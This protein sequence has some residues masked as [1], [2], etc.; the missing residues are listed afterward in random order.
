MTHVTNP[1]GSNKILWPIAKNII[2][3]LAR[4]M[5][6]YHAWS[7]GGLTPKLSGAFWA[8]S[9]GFQDL[10]PFPF[11]SWSNSTHFWKI[12]PGFP[13]QGNTL[14]WMSRVS[15]PR[16]VFVNML[17]KKRRIQ[18]NTFEVELWRLKLT[19]LSFFKCRIFEKVRSLEMLW[20]FQVKVRNFSYLGK[21][22]VCVCVCLCVNFWKNVPQIN[23]PKS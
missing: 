10:G 14:P 13:L 3:G 1:L 17:K 15:N 5:M 23:C 8:L 19:M 6:S 16:R 22:S 12:W 4:I 20:K 11:N 18:R 7:I 9:W 2:G 21:C